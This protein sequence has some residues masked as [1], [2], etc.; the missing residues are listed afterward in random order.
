MISKLALA[1]H[2]KAWLIEPEAAVNL[3]SL[4]ESMLEGNSTLWQQKQEEEVDRL[5]NFR[6]LFAGS[7]Q[8][9]FAPTN[10]WDAKNFKGFDGARQAVIPVQGPLMKSDFCG[11]FGT[12]SLQNLF[13]LAEN[14]P[15]VENIVLLVDSPGGTVDG[16]ESFA[17]TVRNSSKHTTA[18]VDGYAASAAYW[19][20]SSA[21]ELYTSNKTDVIGSIGTMV[22]FYDS[23]KRMEA[24]GVVLREY[25]A[26]KSVDKNRTFREA[27]AGD[28]RAL[29]QEHLDPTNNE[30]LS[31]VKTNRSGKIN[32]ETEDVLT[33]K[34]YLSAKAKSAGLID[35]IMPLDKALSQGLKSAQQKR[36]I[37]MAQQTPF[38]KTLTAAKAESFQVVEGGF[39]LQ[40]ADLNNI[41]A[42]ITGAETTAAQTAQSLADANT[43][44]DAAESS[45]ATAN[46]TVAANQ[47]R[48]TELEAEVT[49]LNK[50]PAS[51]F[52]AT[53]VE[54]DK[55]TT[56]A[57]G[58]KT[59]YHMAIDEEAAK[60][61]R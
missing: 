43:R 52:T 33:G 22:A 15:S 13:R 29:V 30:F 60:Y 38:Q 21:N 24:N 36:K 10:T 26:S 53:A 27:K 9:V 61:R 31:A 47:T 4:W 16:T 35:G 39:L 18:I 58:K 32:L 55:P 25:Y 54:Q 3:L 1:I 20:A 12:A 6:K 17:N 45:L 5:A 37:K 42:V 46:Q 7:G 41:E 50:K 48:I 40:E 49:R 14:T 44:A 28:G 57:A 34:T 56:E 23:S 19:I 2:N 51:E 11:D 59:K 8:T